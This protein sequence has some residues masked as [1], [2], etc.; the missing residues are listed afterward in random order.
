MPLTLRFDVVNGT[1][2]DWRDVVVE[3]ACPPGWQAQGRRMRH[4]D[5]PDALQT[6]AVRLTL[7]DLA[8]G[9][10]AV[11]AFWI[12]GTQP[13]DLIPSW[14]DR[15]R[16]FHEPS[17]PGQGITVCAANVAEQSAHT[18]TATLRALGADGSTVVRVR[19]VPVVIS[20]R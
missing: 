6:G 13:I 16:T 10:R 15:S 8:A 12:S 14:S 18:F 9:Q 3:L 2:A 19:E 20:P 11:A 1:P 17:Q 5:K 7:G 4:W